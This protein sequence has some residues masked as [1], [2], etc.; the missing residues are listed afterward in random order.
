MSLDLICV[1]VVVLG[2]TIQNTSM[3]L[4]EREWKAVL[5][6]RSYSSADIYIDI[7]KILT[8]Y[9]NFICDYEYLFVIMKTLPRSVQRTDYAL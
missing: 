3:C 9:I 7:N 5:V 1:V 4:L 8:I 2:N 6:E